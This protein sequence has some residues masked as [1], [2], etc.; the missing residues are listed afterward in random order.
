[1]TAL[2]PLTPGDPTHRMG[3]HSQPITARRA[4]RKPVKIR[5]GPATVRGIRASTSPKQVDSRKTHWRSRAGKGLST[6]LE[7]GDRFAHLPHIIPRGRDA[8]SMPELRVLPRSPKRSASAPVPSSTSY[9]RVLCFLAGANTDDD[10]G[11]NGE[12]A[13]PFS[14]SSASRARPNAQAIA[15]QQRS[16]FWMTR[17]NPFASTD[18]RAE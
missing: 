16:G 3:P 15:R 7:P 2:T 9:G 1:V 18:R 14:S 12:H 4:T 6:R 13:S 17:A 11:V 8:G 5:R 10:D